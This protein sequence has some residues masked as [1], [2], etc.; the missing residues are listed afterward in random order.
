MGSKLYSADLVQLVAR[1]NRAMSAERTRQLGEN[2][3]EEGRIA[4]QFA[5]KELGRIY[6]FNAGVEKLSLSGVT[7]E[8]QIAKIREAAER[9]TGSK[10][11]T[12]KGR[13]EVEQ[14]RMESFFGVDRGKITSRERKI[15]NTLTEKGGLF[16]KLHEMTGMESPSKNV[17]KA[18]EA[19]QR[20]GLSGKDITETLTE[21]ADQQMAA[22]QD[23]RQTIFDYV[24]EKYPDFNWKAE[25]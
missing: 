5:E 16:D 2:A 9:I 14:Q 21:W 12:A 11:L 25:G 23:E 4:L 13:R 8:D 18:I 1:A 10:L 24:S 3:T 22:A 7:D 19:M 17:Q 20:N 15:W 6:G